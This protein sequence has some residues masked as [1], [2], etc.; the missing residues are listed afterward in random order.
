MGILG[1]IG[2]L[3]AGIAKFI[4]GMISKVVIVVLGIWIAMAVAFWFIMKF[5]FGT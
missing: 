4:L 3:I 1:W 5:V 2:S